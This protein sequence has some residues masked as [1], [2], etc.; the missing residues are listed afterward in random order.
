M[1]RTNEQRERTHLCTIPWATVN[2]EVHS[3]YMTNGM[4]AKQKLRQVD[5]R[6]LACETRTLHFQ[7]AC[8]EGLLWGD[9][10]LDPETTSDIL[11]NV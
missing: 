11:A 6:C 10:P 3:D 9:Q 1:R 8:I 7:A 2:Q 5:E 4:L